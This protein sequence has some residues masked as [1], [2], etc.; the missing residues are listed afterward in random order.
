MGQYGSYEKMVTDPGAVVANPTAIVLEAATGAVFVS[1]PLM[2]PIAVSRFGYAVTV[3]FDY[4]T[5]T[6][7][8]ELTLYRYPLGNASDKVA[9]QTIPLQ[10]ALAAGMVAYADVPNP[11]VAADLKG[12]ADFNAGDVVAIWITTQAAGGTELG[13]FQPYFCWHP[14]A[15]VDANQPLMVNLTP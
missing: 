11:P 7:E 5:Q 3:A 13:D 15:E 1:R 12:K 10:D 8:G 9:L 14:R 4:D 6:V 2:E